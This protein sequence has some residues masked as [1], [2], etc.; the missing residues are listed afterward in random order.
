MNARLSV[1]SLLIRHARILLADGEWLVLDG[2]SGLDDRQWAYCL[3][4]GDDSI[5][6]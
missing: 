1:N 6:D 3:R 2:L 4:T 5:A